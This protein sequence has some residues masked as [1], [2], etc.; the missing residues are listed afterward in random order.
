LDL[1]VVQQ[2]WWWEP[3]GSHDRGQRPEARIEQTYFD[4]FF[5]LTEFDFLESSMDLT[6]VAFTNNAHGE[7]FRSR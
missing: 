7:E 4:V 3:G 6:R 1:A 2:H 5:G